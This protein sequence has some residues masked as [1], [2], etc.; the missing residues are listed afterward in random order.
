MGRFR[1]LDAAGG[2]KA[3]SAL[4]EVFLNGDP[5]RSFG[6]K[7]SPAHAREIR[8]D[9]KSYKAFNNLQAA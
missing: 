8:W 5:W 6:I 2:I 9:V 4:F 7:G 1:H 3:R